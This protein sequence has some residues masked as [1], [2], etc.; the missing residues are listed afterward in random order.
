MLYEHSESI[1]VIANSSLAFG[2]KIFV[3]LHLL[4]P[5]VPAEVVPAFA[6]ALFLTHPG[7]SCPFSV[8]LTASL[9]LAFI[10]TLSLPLKSGKHIANRV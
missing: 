3:S 2:T 6:N 9:F 4:L 8:L 10:F 7:Q 5:P 1:A